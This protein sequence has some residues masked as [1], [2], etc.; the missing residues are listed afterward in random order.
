MSHTLIIDGHPDEESYCSAL[1]N[2]YLEGA[3]NQAGKVDIIR[4]RDLQFDPNLRYGYRQRTELEPDLVKCQELI[5]DAT[6]LVWVYPVWWGSVPAIM[7]G[8]LDRVFLPG[9]AF[10]KREGS[11]FWDRYLTAS[12]TAA[13]A[14]TR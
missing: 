11:M 12:S 4:I 8:F 2:A 3:S 5:K 1:A 9:F 6:H 10:E 14:T 7:K 13:R